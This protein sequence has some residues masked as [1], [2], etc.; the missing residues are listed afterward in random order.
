VS[1]PQWLPPVPPERPAPAS[2]PPAARAGAGAPRSY[3]LPAASWWSRVVATLLDGL[4]VFVVALAVGALAAATGG[5]SSGAAG[6][7]SVAFFLVALVYAPLLLATNEGRTIGKQALGIRVVTA[8]GGAPGWRT[9]FLRE[10]VVKGAFGIVG[11]ALL[12]DVLVPLFDGHQRAL[13][14]MVCA[15]RV[16]SDVRG[17]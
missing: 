14:D 1:E 16:V 9:A 4:I 3:A 12:V 10:L 11:V 15:T 17:Y 8:D 6:V 2:R 13:H 5:R 7:G